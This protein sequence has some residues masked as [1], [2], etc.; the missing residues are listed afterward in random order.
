[1]KKSQPPKAKKAVAVKKISVNSSVAKKVKKSS[2]NSVVVEQ[3]IG[4]DKLAENIADGMIRIACLYAEKWGTTSDIGF[5]AMYGQEQGDHILDANKLKRSLEKQG[6][7]L[8]N[9]I[10][11]KG[12]ATKGRLKGKQFI[13]NGGNVEKKIREIFLRC[14]DR[15]GVAVA[16]PEKKSV[17]QN[18]FSNLQTNFNYKDSEKIGKRGI[19]SH[20][21]AY[22]AFS[23]KNLDPVYWQNIEG[24]KRLFKVLDEAADSI[25]LEK[26]ESLD[27]LDDD[28][29]ETENDSG[30]I[31]DIDGAEEGSPKYREHLIRE[32]NRSLIL[33][34][35]KLASSLSCEVCGFNFE[36]K[37]G[38]LGEE[39][40]EVHH[41]IPLSSLEKSTKTKLKDLAIV[42]SNCHRMLHR[43]RDEFLTIDDL[44]KKIEKKM[45]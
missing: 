24:W 29:F 17:L 22:A 23:H 39:Y 43:R 30:D 31:P 38:S 45:L 25:D 1:M 19:S 40:C 3:P 12:R 35:K 16:T 32:R 21:E 10:E 2:E 13:L 41:K 15:F 42:C 37:Y 5:V 36:K 4:K 28:F 9:C 20:I 11:N 27:E 14:I 33:R 34:K 18:I 6:K 44:K 26:E 7:N 8:V